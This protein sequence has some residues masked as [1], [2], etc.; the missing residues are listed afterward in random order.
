[1]M[2]KLEDY[3]QDL[4]KL[5]SRYM[6]GEGTEPTEVP[7]LFFLRQSYTNEPRHIFHKPSLCIILQGEKEICLAE[8][9]FCY[10]PSD[11]LISSLALPVTGQVTEATQEKPYISL[12]LEFIPNQVIDLI[13]D[14]DKHEK[15]QKKQNR[16]MYVGQIELPLMDAVARLVRL[17]ERPEDIP[18]LAPIYTK[19]IFYRLLMGKYGDTLRQFTI[20]DSYA[21][22]IREIVKEITQN[23]NQAMRI[24]EIAKKANI[25]VPTLH[26]QFKDVTAMSPLQFQKQLRLQEARQ[27][28]LAESMDAADA[29]F[30][31]G[32]ES[33]SQFSREYLRM[34]G[35]PP[36]EDIKRLRARYA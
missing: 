15:L 23:Y 18:I 29:A 1:M 21:Y 4:A 26:R 9:R 25:S 16:A 13:H 24:D 35:Y 30:Q 5:I 28:M 22:Q 33:P 6:Q 2:D 10:G 7:S 12:K 14:V 27:L 36:R 8:Q 19:E 20:K 34:F 11:Y 3:S 17:V 31:V 32:Y